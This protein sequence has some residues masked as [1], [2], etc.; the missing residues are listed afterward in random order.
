[1]SESMNDG[2]HAPLRPA[3][4]TSGC[5]VGGTLVHTKDGLRPIEQIRVGDLVLQAD[6]PH[7]ETAYKRVLRTF[8]HEAKSVYAVFLMVDDNLS[9]TE[10]IFVSASQLFWVAGRNWLRADQ[11]W[12]GMVPHLPSGA[13]SAIVC[14]CRLVQASATADVGW[15]Q[16][17]VFGNEETDCGQFVDFRRGAPEVMWPNDH[18]PVPNDAERLQG[19]DDGALPRKVY[20]IHVEGSLTYHV[21]AH[22]VLVRGLTDD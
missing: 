8:E 2:A 15:V 7:G 21:G 22:G 9:K 3:R 5:L 18:E 19:D 12:V 11:L 10:S 4:A 20:D 16:S 6:H 14:S 13:S 17:L 1:M